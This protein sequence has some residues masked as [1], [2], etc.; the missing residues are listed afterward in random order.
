MQHDEMIWQVINSQFCSYKKVLGSEKSDNRKFCCHPYSVSGLCNRSHCPL[1][2]SRY[3]T[4]RE[5]DGR[6]NLYIKTVERAHTPKNM[7]EEI[8]LARNYSKALVQLE[9]HLA[10]YPKALIH[11][12]KQRLTKIHQYLS[13]MRSIKLKE[14]SGLKAKINGINRKVDKRE[15]RKEVKAMIAAKIESNIEKELVERLSKG[16]YGDIYN[17][18]DTPYEKVLN[19]IC[20]D[21]KVGDETKITNGVTFIEDLEEDG[22][23]EDFGIEYNND[24]V[25]TI[26]DG[27]NLLDRIEIL[28][29]EEDVRQ[30]KDL[31]W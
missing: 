16:A 8:K 29:E 28:Y 13:R 19:E 11:R 21:K 23:E 22:N 17:Y 5:T 4:L 2:N 18:P 7:W 14:L 24:E 1:A 3:A 6:I 31:T 26:N 12:N 30:S 25:D 27:K 15:E 10:F 20:K 9:K